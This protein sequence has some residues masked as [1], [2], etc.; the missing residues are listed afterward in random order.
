MISSH[1]VVGQRFS[2]GKGVTVWHFAN[3]EDDVTVG[4]FAV[5]GSHVFVGR[6]T[7]IG[8]GTRIQ[9]GAF[10][11]RRAVI[12]AGV[13]VGPLAVLTDDKYPRTSNADYLAEPPMLMDN[14]SISAGAVVLPG[15]TVGRGAMVGAG[16]VVVRDVPDGGTVMGVPA[17][18][19]G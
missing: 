12:G 1:A 19:P 15:V 9:S 18:I 8:N 17:R 16:A 11:C 14:C 13:F 4:D 6:G 7:K 10:I 5:I 2:F 3:V